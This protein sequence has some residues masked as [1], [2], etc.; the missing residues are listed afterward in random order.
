M[1]LDGQPVLETERLHLRPL[2]GEDREALYAIASDPAVWE[3]HPI[4][5][6]WRR[7]VFDA[8]FDESLGSGGGL[9]VVR[10]SDSAI[11]GHSRY[12]EVELDEEG[13]VIEIGWTF[14]APMCWGKGLNHEMKSAMLGHAFAAADVVEFRVGDTN[15]RSRNALEAIGAVRTERYELERY[16]GKRVVHLVYAITREAFENGPLA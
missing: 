7:E 3:Q 11:V 1:T 2:T 9:T 10:K 6:R 4:H 15:Y 5:D 16:Q 12:G 14:L 13:D 8:F